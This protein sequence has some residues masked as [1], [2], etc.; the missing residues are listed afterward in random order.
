MQSLVPKIYILGTQLFEFDILAFSQTWLNPSVLSQG[1]HIQTFRDP[2][3]KDRVGD[4]HGGV[5]QPPSHQ[6]SSQNVLPRPNKIV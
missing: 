2:E 6:T 4:S 5:D 3:R 1:L